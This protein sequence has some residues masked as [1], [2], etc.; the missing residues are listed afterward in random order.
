MCIDCNL[1]NVHIR[2]AERTENQGP[3]DNTHADKQTAK[4]NTK[5]SRVSNELHDKI[6][7]I[8]NI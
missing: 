6:S 7:M 4:I 1:P 2:Y 5:L 8:N 3:H